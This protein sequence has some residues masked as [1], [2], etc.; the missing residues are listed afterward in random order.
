MIPTF[1]TVADGKIVCG[2]NVKAGNI[3]YIFCWGPVIKMSV[4]LK[5]KLRKLEFSHVFN[6]LTHIDIDVVWWIES[7]RQAVYI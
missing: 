5:F 6:S 1:L 7:G 3:S 4:L 2:I